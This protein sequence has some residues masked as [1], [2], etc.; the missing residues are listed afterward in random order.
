[1][2]AG[3]IPPHPFRWF[4]PQHQQF[5]HRHLL[6]SAYLHT[7]LLGR[8]LLSVSA[9]LLSALLCLGSLSHFV[10]RKLPALPL[11]LRELVVCWASAMILCGDRIALRQQ[12]ET[13]LGYTSFV[14]CLSGIIVP[15]NLVSWK[16]LF[17]IFHCLI[18]C[19]SWE[20][21]P[22]LCSTP[23]LEAEISL[24]L[25]LRIFHCMDALQFIYLFIEGLGCFHFFCCN[26]E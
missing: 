25:L 4:L 21:K 16:L 9:A 14:S 8:C 23:W 2:R 3:S 15:Q 26:Y 18:S 24:M 10:F 12:V 13:N 11:L 1:M 22:S 6:L 5:L 17:H 19:F 7:S 20:G